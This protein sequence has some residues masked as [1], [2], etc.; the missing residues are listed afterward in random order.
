MRS[1]SKKSHLALIFCTYLFLYLPILVLIIFS[2]N[3]QKFPSQWSGFTLH[4][5]KEL[6]VSHELWSA[7]FTSLFVAITSTAISLLMGLSFIFFHFSGGKVKRALPMFYTNLI[8]PEI[9]LS[10]SLLT[11][12]VFFKVTLG[13]TTLIIAHTVLGLGFVI[14]ML[15]SRYSQL[16]TSIF[17][18][19][20]L[21][22]ASELKTFTS[23]VI[24]LLK[25]ALI[26]SGILIFILSFDDFIFSCFCAGTAVETISLYLLSMLRLGISPVVNALSCLLF[27]VSTV[28]ALVFL[29]SR[30]RG[31]DLI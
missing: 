19:A 12:F 17:Q 2:F 10:I 24:P 22:G 15:Y 14:P 23:V 25:P 27:L 26:S 21:L 13:F 5:Y 11:F 30:N 28:A 31:G 18:A 1:K 7:F 4:W 6:F 9:M 16:D 20:T 3:G 8:I 29:S